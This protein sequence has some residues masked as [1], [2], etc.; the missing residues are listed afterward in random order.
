VS[1]RMG[2]PSFRIF[3]RGA[4]NLKK[5]EG[6]KKVD[7][8]QISEVDTLVFDD[9]ERSMMQPLSP[10]AWPIILRCYLLRV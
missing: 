10:L 8:N 4:S 2:A 3:R 7:R 5:R 9:L 6:A 1:T